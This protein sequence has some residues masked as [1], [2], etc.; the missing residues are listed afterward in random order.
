MVCALSVAWKLRAP[1]EHR[2]AC[3]AEELALHAN[4]NEAEALILA[5][6]EMDDDAAANFNEFRATAFED[7]DYEMLFDAARRRH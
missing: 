7:W 5:E 2:L 4:V 3:T 6:P 1:G